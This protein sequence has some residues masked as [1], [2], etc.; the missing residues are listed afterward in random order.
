M[1]IYKLDQTQFK[2][3][4]CRVLPRQ[5]GLSVISLAVGLYIGMGGRFDLVIL[6]ISLPIIYNRMDRYSFN[7]Q[8]VI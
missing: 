7:N 6:F 8:E 1:Q 5:I 4:I 3:V 2:Q